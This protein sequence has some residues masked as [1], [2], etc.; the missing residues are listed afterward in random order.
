LI[1]SGVAGQRVMGQQVAGQQVARQQ[2][3][4]LVIVVDAVTHKPLSFASAVYRDTRKG[5]IADVDGRLLVPAGQPGRPLTISRIGYQSK[6]LTG[7]ELPDSVYL[8]PNEEAL[9]SVVVHETDESDPRAAWIIRQSIR[10]KPENNPDALSG[11]TYTSYSKMVVDTTLGTG[12]AP[13]TV[14]DKHLFVLESV[15]SHAYRKPLLRKETVEAQKISGLKNGYFLGLATQLQYFSFY[16][17]DFSLLGI[18]YANPVSQKYKGVYVFH[19]TDSVRGEDSSLTWIISFRPRRNKFGLNFLQGEVHIHENDFG[20]VNVIAAPATKNGQFNISF[21]QQYTR[22]KEHWF[23]AQLNTD[24]AIFPSQKSTDNS[25]GALIIT[26][27]GYIRDVAIDSLVSARNFGHYQYSISPEANDRPRSYWDDHRTIALDTLDKNTY[28]FLDSIEKA[29]PKERVMTAV[30]NMAGDLLHGEIPAGRINLVISQLVRYD[31][32]EG[33]RLG[34]GF[35]TNNRVSPDWRVGAYGGYGFGDKSVK[36]GA[37]FEHVAGADHDVTYGIRY[38]R[39]IALAGSNSFAGTPLINIQNLY[40][41]KA[42]SV[43]MVEVYRKAWL[44]RIIQSRFFVDFQDRIFTGGYH[45][46]D[47]SKQNIQYNGLHIVEAGGSFNTDFAQG[48][49]KSNN[50]TI[51]SLDF[52]RKNYLEWEI[53]VGKSVDAG[54]SVDYEKV[55][56]RYK[57]EFSLGR[58]GKVTAVLEGGKVF[59]HLPYGMLFSN[60]GTY[61]HYGLNIPATFQTMRWYEFINDAYGAL[62]VDYETGYLVQRRGKFGMT[63]ELAQNTGIGALSAPQL[64]VGIPA[65]AITQP[66]TEAGAGIRLRTTRRSYHVMVLYR[67]GYY[68]LPKMGDN[69]SFRL[70][71]Q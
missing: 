68:Q 38:T 2:A 40:S 35:V 55:E 71:L 10:N 26:T 57:R 12:K 49:L 28:H 13:A 48:L 45:F 60:L 51:N 9:E 50:L 6:K 33:L 36:Y 1:L 16:P 62:F 37:S 19:L 11:Y 70:A 34:F 30:M 29:H 23:P 63:L 46:L 42:D 32:Y 24:I 47:P 59:G 31:S 25:G 17:D 39:D 66:Y 43:Q 52:E 27:R 8:S 54:S 7:P 5:F 4:R 22:V 21:R 58:P 69:F 18:E 61:E 41:S 53:K 67:Y 56:A 44:A 64:Q 20:F 14:P 65:R 15:I 3:P